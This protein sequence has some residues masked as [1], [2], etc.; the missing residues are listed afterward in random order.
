MEASWLRWEAERVEH[1]NTALAARLSARAITQMRVER[2]ELRAKNAEKVTIITHMRDAKYKALWRAV[3]LDEEIAA[4][5]AEVKVLKAME[6]E[7]AATADTNRQM[8]VHF[9]YLALRD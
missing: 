1:E 5:K 9:A 6:A 8:T 3:A 4:L 2:R 7:A